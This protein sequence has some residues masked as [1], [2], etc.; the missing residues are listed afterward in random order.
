MSSDSWDFCDTAGQ[1]PK[2]GHLEGLAWGSG[3]IWTEDQDF[4]VIYRRSLK[5]RVRIKPSKE[6]V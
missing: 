4:G 6:N 1:G 2:R 3:E 5:T